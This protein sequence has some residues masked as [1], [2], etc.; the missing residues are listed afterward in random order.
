[1]KRLTKLL[2]LLLALLAAVMAVGLFA[3]WNVWPVIVI[4]WSVLTVKNTVDVGGVYH[5][6]RTGCTCCRHTA[7]RDRGAED[8][9]R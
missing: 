3:G 2:I 8:G 5:G 1:M 4:Y 6:H 7:D 9:R